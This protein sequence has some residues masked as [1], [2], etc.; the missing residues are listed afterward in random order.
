MRYFYLRGPYVVKRLYYVIKVLTS[1]YDIPKSSK[2]LLPL[3]RFLS[4]N[5]TLSTVKKRYF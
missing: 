4:D 2:D 1:T 3:M 5:K